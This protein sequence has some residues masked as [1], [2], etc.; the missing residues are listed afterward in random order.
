MKGVIL[1]GGTASRLYP[2]TTV[3]NKHLL[4]VGRIPMIYHSILKFKE[5]GIKKIMIITSPSHM[6]DVVRQLGSGHEFGVEFTYKVQ[7]QAGGI[8]QAIG[9]AENFIGDDLFGV[10]LGDNIFEDS[11]KKY[12]EKFESQ[13][14][15]AM[16]FLKIVKDP[17]RFGVAE[18]DK[19]GIVLSIEEKPENPKSFYAVTGL[20]FYDPSVFSIIKKLKPSA[21][22]ELEVTDIN[23]AY[24]KRNELSSSI[25]NGFWTDAGTFSSYFYANSLVKNIEYKI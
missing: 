19:D 10:I 20:Y 17:K 4:P 14:K 18:I 2:L 21:R 9:L 3:T 25:I 8:A 15:G 11:I 7:D 5:S 1:A 16:V 22:G 23:N 24:L 6:G 13:K 12:K